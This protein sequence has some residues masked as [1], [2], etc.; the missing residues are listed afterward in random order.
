[1]TNPATLQDVSDKLDH[2]LSL[3]M[4]APGAAP[5]VPAYDRPEL[6]V[7]QVTAFDG[8]TVQADGSVWAIATTDFSPGGS[9]PVITAGTKYRLS[10]GYISPVKTPLIWEMGQ[11]W[12][13]NWAAVDAAWRANPY[14]LY[15]ADIVAILKTQDL[16]QNNFILLGYLMSSYG[17][18]WQP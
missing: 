8:V 7:D 11:K 15:K 1:M 9:G 6:T 18:K 16:T 2:L 17:S 5:V 12:S 10:Y 3:A 13:A 4:A 14:Q